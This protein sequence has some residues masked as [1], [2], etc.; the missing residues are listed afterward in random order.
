MHVRVLLV[1]RVV[2]VFGVVHVRV[3]G[4][5]HV[6]VVGV[7]RVVEVRAN[8][9]AC[10]WAPPIGYDLLAQPAL[11]TENLDVGVSANLTFGV[12]SAG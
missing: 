12:G 3:F 9:S 6:R 10:T 1:R 4:V 11:D 8:M 7:R 5:V 2:H